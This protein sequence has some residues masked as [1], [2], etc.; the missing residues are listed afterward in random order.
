MVV[1]QHPREKHRELP[2]YIP[3]PG[4]PP[5]TF[6]EVL[7]QALRAVASAQREGHLTEEET[8]LLLRQIFSAWLSDRIHQTIPGVLDWSL[9]HRW[10]PP[11]EGHG[12]WLATLSN[13]HVSW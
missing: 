11:T 1:E 4:S 7:A 9:P 2:G 13:R 3:S 8:D 6:E 12:R 5:A 10:R